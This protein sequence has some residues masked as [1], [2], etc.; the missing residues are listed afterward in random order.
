MLEKLETKPKIISREKS[1]LPN[2]WKQSLVSFVA[3]RAGGNTFCFPNGGKVFQFCLGNST[4]HFHPLI[5]TELNISGWKC[6]LEFPR[7]N[8]KISGFFKVQ[9]V[10]WRATKKVLPKSRSGNL[11]STYW[12]VQVGTVGLL[13]LQA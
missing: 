1:Y 10:T 12:A 5:W 4:E 9:K 8:R 6:F 11:K 13:L 2:S 7:E 3:K